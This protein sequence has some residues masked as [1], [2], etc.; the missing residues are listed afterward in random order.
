MEN[1]EEAHKYIVVGK[2][3]LKLMEFY[4]DK[5]ID[6]ILPNAIQYILNNQSKED[7]NARNRLSSEL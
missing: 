1:T 3:K 2:R 6:E 7:A 5:P 4:G